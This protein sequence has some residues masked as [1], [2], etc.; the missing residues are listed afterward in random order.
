MPIDQTG[1]G[2]YRIPANVKGQG[3][4]WF[5]FRL[6]HTKLFLIHIEK[7]GRRHAYRILSQFFYKRHNIIIR[8]KTDS[9]CFTCHFSLEYPH[10]IDR[11]INNTDSAALHNKGN[12]V[13][14]C[15]AKYFADI[16][17]NCDLPFCHDLCI[18]NKKIINKKIILNTISTILILTNHPYRRKIISVLTINPGGR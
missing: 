5:G 1:N 6:C 14:A 3:R 17:G 18:I 4:K 15:Y 11:R 7:F 12:S 8:C 16:F 10:G 13:T 9:F 2:Q